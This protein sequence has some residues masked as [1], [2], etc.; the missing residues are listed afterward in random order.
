MVL[1]PGAFAALV[2]GI[3]TFFVLI[4]VLLFYIRSRRRENE[5]GDTDT[6]RLIG[7]R[8]TGTSFVQAESGTGNELKSPNGMVKFGGP[9]SIYWNK[10]M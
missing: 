8:N 1:S 6:T 4:G 7:K 3:I 9:T 10:Y 2:L 5:T